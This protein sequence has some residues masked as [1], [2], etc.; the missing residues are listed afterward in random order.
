MLA[1]GLL[2]FVL[3]SAALA[4]VVGSGASRFSRP[5]DPA[6]LYAGLACFAGFLVIGAGFKLAGAPPI[7]KDRPWVGVTIVVLALV[8]LVVGIVLD[9]SN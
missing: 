5:D 6:M 3:A 9:V 4:L 8:G 2:A 1:L 7:S